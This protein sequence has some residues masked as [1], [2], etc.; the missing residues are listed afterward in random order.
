MGNSLQMKIAIVFPRKALT[1]FGTEKPRWIG[2]MLLLDVVLQ[3]PFL[4]KRQRAL[5]TIVAMSTA[6]F[7]V[8]IELIFAE[9]FSTCRTR[10]WIRDLRHRDSST[11]EQVHLA[12]SNISLQDN[13]IDVK[14]F[15]LRTGMPGQAVVSHVQAKAIDVKPIVVY[16]HVWASTLY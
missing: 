5:C 13:S 1:T 15:V 7:L 12:C 3:T 2:R 8:I 14:P 10:A 6:H 16:R 4:C 11:L 9:W